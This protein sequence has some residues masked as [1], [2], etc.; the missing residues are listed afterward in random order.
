MPDRWGVCD[1]I[2][3]FPPQLKII[4]YYVFFLALSCWSKNLEKVGVKFFAPL[5]HVPFHNRYL[6]IQK[7]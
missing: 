5:Y 4:D 3:H 1:G 6:F 2:E 7:H